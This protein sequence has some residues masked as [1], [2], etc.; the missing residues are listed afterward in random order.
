M[1]FNMMDNHVGH[2]SKRVS[3]LLLTGAEG[4]VVH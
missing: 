2:Y 1:V 4:G 3:I